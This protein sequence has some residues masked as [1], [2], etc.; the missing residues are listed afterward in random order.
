MNSFLKL[1]TFDYCKNYLI[2]DFLLL[3]KHFTWFYFSVCIVTVF[4]PILY[5]ISWNLKMHTSYV[6][7]RMFTL[8]INC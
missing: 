6:K 2:Q 7:F 4:I 5:I 1:L 3:S 8:V